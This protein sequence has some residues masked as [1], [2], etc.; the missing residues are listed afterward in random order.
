MRDRLPTPAVF[1]VPASPDWVR[2]GETV[3]RGCNVRAPR[4]FASQR[5]EH[6]TIQTDHRRT[7]H[8][9]GTGQPFI[10]Q[11]SVN[12]TSTDHRSSPHQPSIVQRRINRALAN[13]VLTV[14]RSAPHQPIIGQPCINRVSVSAAATEHRSTLNH[15]SSGTATSVVA[16]RL[17]PGCPRRTRPS[18]RVPRIQPAVLPTVH[19]SAVESSGH[20]LSKQSCAADRADRS[21]LDPLSR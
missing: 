17:P 16:T 1:P 12:G 5:R 9:P 11:A 8:Q 19:R 14:Y 13:L 10:N 20:T 21:D 4:P 6:P 2:R 7:L 15:R 3:K 18:R